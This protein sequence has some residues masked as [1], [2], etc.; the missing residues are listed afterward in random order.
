MNGLGFSEACTAWRAYVTKLCWTLGR[1]EKKPGAF[2]SSLR[3]NRSCLLSTP[4][5]SGFPWSFLVWHK[6]QTMQLDWTQVKKI[7]DSK[8]SNVAEQSCYLV[9]PGT[10]VSGNMS[11]RINSISYF[12]VYL[13]G[14]DKSLPW[15]G[16]NFCISWNA[17]ACSLW[18]FHLAKFALTTACPC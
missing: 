12:P 7:T 1:K 3:W 11:L 18:E 16:L 2:C 8:F 13:R 14:E 6:H 4:W 15:E 10:S 5:M 17:L 9:A